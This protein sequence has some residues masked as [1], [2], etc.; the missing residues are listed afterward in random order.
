M[1]LGISMLMSKGIP[2]EPKMFSF[3]EPLSLD[4][5]LYLATTYIIVSVILLICA[6]Y[7]I[8]SSENTV[9]MIYLSFTITQTLANSLICQILYSLN[10]YFYDLLRQPY[11]GP[12]ILI[13]VLT[14]IAE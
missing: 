5:W 1:T 8:K 6:R 9:R 13:L 2:E 11:R 7:G 4:V 12:L 10:L 14:V 3:L